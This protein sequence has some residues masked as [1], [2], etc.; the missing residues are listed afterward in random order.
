MPDSWFFSDTGKSQ[1]R[2]IQ[3]M[4]PVEISCK[5]YIDDIERALIANKDLLSKHFAQADKDADPPSYA[6]FYK[7]RN[8][9]HLRRED[10]LR[11]VG[12]LIVATN[13]MVKVDLEK[14]KKAILVEVLQTV[15][16]M[17]IVEDYMEFSKYNLHLVGKPA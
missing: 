6:I 13:P 12:D 2:F 7:A 1:S 8:N 17:S 5:A 14:P 11:A 3:R 15:A 16:C 9:D 4:L 10:I